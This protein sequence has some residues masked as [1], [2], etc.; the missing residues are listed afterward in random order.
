MRF[1]FS[2]V[3]RSIRSYFRPVKVNPVQYIPEVVM[4]VVS[5]PDEMEPSAPA[6]GSA[7]VSEDLPESRSPIFQASDKRAVIRKPSNRKKR[8]K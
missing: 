2:D 3:I 4:P 6:P 7:P 5:V 1:S 8:R